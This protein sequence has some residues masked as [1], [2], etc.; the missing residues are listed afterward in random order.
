MTRERM[1]TMLQGIIGDDEEESTLSTYLDLAG[2]KIINRVYPYRKDN[3]ELE[4]PVK[5]HALQVEICAA[6]LNKRGA[7]LETQ[8]IENGIHRNWKSADIPDDMLSQIVPY[9]G[10]IGG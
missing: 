10:V 1:I 7:E 9:V 4:V 5:Y 6:M 2:E 8:H 3:E